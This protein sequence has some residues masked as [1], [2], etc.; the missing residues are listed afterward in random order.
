MQKN[1]YFTFVLIDIMVFDI[2]QKLREPSVMPNYRLIHYLICIV[3]SKQFPVF[4]SPL[5]WN[6]C[7]NLHYESVLLVR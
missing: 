3:V 5:A 6:I 2:T 7:E 4:I 1:I